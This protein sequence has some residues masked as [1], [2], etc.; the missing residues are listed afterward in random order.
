MKEQEK[1]LDEFV[2]NWKSGTEQVDDILVI[3]VRL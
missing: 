2:E 3:R 1:Y